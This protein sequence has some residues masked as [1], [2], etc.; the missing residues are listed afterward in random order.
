MLQGQLSYHATQISSIATVQILLHQDVTADYPQ[1]ALL[2]KKVI[3]MALRMLGWPE[4]PAQCVQA[5]GR[6]GGCPEI[7]HF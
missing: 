5:L 4:C 1:L 6:G 3:C 7:H 2:M